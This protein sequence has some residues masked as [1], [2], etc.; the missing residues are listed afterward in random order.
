MA[1]LPPQTQPGLW[2]QS[3]CALG[4]HPKIHKLSRLLGISRV[5]AVGHMQFFWWWAMEY[6]PDG[7]LSPFDALDIAIAGHWEG[8][9]EQ[10]FSALIAA[11]FIEDH[12]IHDWD[13]YGGK[14]L[15]KRRQDA[16]RKQK[17]RDIHRT[18]YGRDADVHTQSAVRKEQEKNREEKNGS[19]SFASANAPKAKRATPLPADFSVTDEMTNWA[20]AEH[21]TYADIEEQ[22]ALFLDHF[23]AN[24]KAMKDWPATWRNWMRRSR[25]FARGSPNGRT[26]YSQPQIGPKGPNAAWFA[27]KAKAREDHERSGRGESDSSLTK[28]L[29]GPD[30]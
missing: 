8:D 1:S 3:Y 27:A 21:F 11:R 16:D 25:T 17:D 4:D 20:L 7:D 13:K 10:F 6:A 23:K 22:T 18:S 28:M 14:L 29:R 9:E 2:I 12:E 26:D 24:G 5:T 30:G 15:K 19:L